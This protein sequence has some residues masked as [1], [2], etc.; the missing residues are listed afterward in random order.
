MAILVTCPDCQN[1][2]KVADATGGKTIR[3]PECNGRVPVPAV[4]EPDEDLPDE[5]E[6]EEQRPRKKKKRAAARRAVHPLLLVG[7]G[8]VLLTG[9]VVAV[10][11]L[12]GVFAGKKPAPVAQAGPEP[13]PA[14]APPRP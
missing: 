12:A 10:L 5:D 14:P 3:C 4:G 9:G 11:A 8:T 1:P 6:E 2:L 13:A 7:L